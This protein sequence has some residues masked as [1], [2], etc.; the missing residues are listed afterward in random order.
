MEEVKQ[1]W[2]MD[3]KCFENENWKEDLAS[4]LRCTEI[5]QMI[6]NL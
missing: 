4:E 2:I 3:T 6:E 5:M 1:E